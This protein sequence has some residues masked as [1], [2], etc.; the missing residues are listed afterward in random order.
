MSK[1]SNSLVFMLV[2]TL[3]NLLLLVVCFVVFGVI[4]TL[5]MSKI[6]S[7]QEAGGISML[8]VLLWFGLSIGGSFLIY[9]KLVKW[10]IAKYDLE[11]KLDPLFTPKKSRKKREE[12]V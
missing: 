9:N 1:K 12:E 8:F 2:M 11:N 10:L 3:V 7:L 5:I 6:P 4:I